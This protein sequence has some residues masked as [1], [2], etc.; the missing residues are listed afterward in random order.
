MLQGCAKFLKVMM[1]NKISKTLS[2]RLY[3][4]LDQEDLLSMPSHRMRDKSEELL[5]TLSSLLKHLIFKKE[6]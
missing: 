6:F 4:I 1:Q 5:S 3:P 2:K